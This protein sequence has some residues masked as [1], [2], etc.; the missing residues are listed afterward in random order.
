MSVK[1]L[2]AVRVRIAALKSEAHEIERQPRSRAEVREKVHAQID[3][4]REQGRLEA[5][6]ALSEIAYGITGIARLNARVHDEYVGIRTPL[7]QADLGPALVGLLGAE[8]VGAFLLADLE[9]IPE[10]LDR[11]ERAARL[12]E[13]AAELDKLE[14]DEEAIVCALE[15]EGEAVMRRADARPEIVL[16]TYEAPANKG[17]ALY[18]EQDEA[19]ARMQ[20]AQGGR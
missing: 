12:A 9:T 3:A 20:R 11:G 14:R 16:G 8:V 1:K 6:R 2:E 15:A 13:I 19:N 10:G 18:R 7:G 17:A 4:W 5:R